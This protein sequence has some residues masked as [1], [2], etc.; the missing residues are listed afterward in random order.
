MADAAEQLDAL[1]SST[2]VVE[3]E[4]AQSV[5]SFIS[6]LLESPSG[7]LDVGAASGAGSDAGFDKETTKKLQSSVTQLATAAP[8]DSGELVLTSENLNVTTIAVSDPDELTAQPLTCATSGAPAAVAMPRGLLSGVAGFDPSQPISALLYVTATPLHRTAGVALGTDG[9]S[10]VGGGGSN[11]SLT[12]LASPMVSFSLLQDGE[13]L[14]VSGVSERIN[15]SLALLDS[16]E[17]SDICFGKKDKKCTSVV[18]CR[19]W[20]DEGE[21][22]KTDGCFT[23]AT[24]D[25]GVKC[26]CDHLTDFMVFEFPST[27]E[28]LAADAENAASITGFS[29]AALACANPLPDVAI[30]PLPWAVVLGILALGV[31]LLLHAAHRDRK[32]QLKLLSLEK[33]EASVSRSMAR[34]LVSRSSKKLSRNSDANLVRFEASIDH[35]ARR[36]G[37]HAERLS[38]VAPETE[39]SRTSPPPSPPAELSRE[40]SQPALADWQLHR[41]ASATDQAVTPVSAP[42]PAI[43]PVNA[44]SSSRTRMLQAGSTWRRAAAVVSLDLKQERLA[45]VW[46]RTAVHSIRHRLGVALRSRH[47]LLAALYR[48]AGSLSRAQTVQVFLNSLALQLVV[49]SMF[50]WPREPGSPLTINPVKII[51]TG[52]ISALI[53]TPCGAIF[54][55]T[56]HPVILA[57]VIV[58]LTLRL[59]YLL[60]CFPCVIGSCCM[61]R[62]E[63]RRLRREKRGAAATAEPETGDGESKPSSSAASRHSELLGRGS[64]VSRFDDDDEE[65]DDCEA[66][67]QENALEKGSLKEGRGAKGSRASTLHS[68]AEEQPPPGDVAQGE[69]AQ[70]APPE[71]SRRRKASKQVDQPVVTWRFWKPTGSSMDSDMNTLRGAV[72]TIA[73]DEHEQANAIDCDEVEDIPNAT[74]RYRTMSLKTLSERKSVY[75]VILGWA[76]NWII[77]LG[78]L[79]VFFIYVCEFSVNTSVTNAQ[80]AHNELMLAWTWSIIQRIVFNEPLVIVSMK[81]IPM[82]LRSRACACLFSE[83][84]VEY[85]GII[86]EAVGVCLQ[87]LV[88]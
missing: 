69:K 82:L 9:S 53:T 5:T 38:R 25:G 11:A 68:V 76:L 18:Q 73:P 55:V 59:I 47:S 40:D 50:F 29:P 19:W 36:L 83:A 71:R 65:E 60:L 85:A 10:S 21:T 77:L 33:R 66:A 80:L 49:V 13:A 23:L 43:A 22:W 51:I 6:R 14:E 24:A 8:P 1:L 31:P 64:I 32:A 74:M 20:D 62:R 75:R 37:L 63:A 45:S 58:R 48:G 57:R 12:R 39:P 15:V 52:T 44:R 54:A 79:Q 72:A 41:S 42:A 88:N 86:I 46:R 17:T 2:D 84:C 30:A 61:R 35:R 4:I 70:K 56:F 78:L 27:V 81:G 34:G 28:Q 26:S 16:P 87:E 3:P 7:G 67:T